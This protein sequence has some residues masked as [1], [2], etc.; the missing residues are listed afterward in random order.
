MQGNGSSEPSKNPFNIS[1]IYVDQSGP[2]V[3]PAAQYIQIMI[4]NLNSFSL[5]SAWMTFLTTILYISYLYMQ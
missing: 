2:S 4:F 1:V 3:A 5:I